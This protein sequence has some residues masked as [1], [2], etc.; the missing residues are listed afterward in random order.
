MFKEYM[1]NIKLISKNARY[2]LVG[3]ALNGIGLAVFSLLFNLYL[4]EIGYSE[5]QIG[6]ILS[7]GSLGATFVAIP[8]AFVIEKI[9]IKHTL[10][11]ATVLASFSYVMQVVFV[12][13]NIILFFSFLATMFI[14]VYRISVA[15]FFMRNSTP[16]ERMHL[17][18]I[19]YAMMTFS[20]FLGFFLGGYL[21]KIYFFLFGST[22]KI[23]AFKFALYISIFMTMLSI[24]YFLKIEQKPIP[25][26]KVSFLEKMKSY[27][28]KI[29]TKLMV[30]KIFVGM[31][32]GLVIPFMNLY[33][34]NV[35]HLD[36]DIIGI[37]FSVLQI[38]LFLAMLSAP[39]LTKRF[40]MVKS[41][42]FTEL[43]SIPFMLTLA[44]TKN[45]TLAVIAFFLRGSIMNMNM[46]I[47]SN[48]EMSLVK[49][50][51]QP[52][53]NAVSMVSWNGAWTISA[54]F[55][56]FII[57]KYSFEFSFYITI[58]FYIFS[59]FSY[60][61]FFKKYEKDDLNEKLPVGLE[62]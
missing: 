25:M 34:R 49:K 21:P 55:G 60:Y 53:V 51:E 2:F 7:A 62:K 26:K 23:F 47:S 15:P 48:F 17:F 14:T 44:L 39:F 30:P 37:Y 10:I 18:S 27:N 46:P 61:L 1:E 35:F 6:Y 58:I 42:V 56:G 28:W 9:H 50:E 52:F 41:I 31:G 16:K 57:D 40:G 22:N 8:A 33:F 3:G 24:I 19:S 32:A 4:K 12:K 5:T 36:A 43:L 45:L 38:F 11:I 59:A 13:L 29:I 54:W 20:Q